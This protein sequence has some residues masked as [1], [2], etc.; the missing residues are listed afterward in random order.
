M[1]PVLELNLFDFLKRCFWVVKLLLRWERL[2]VLWVALVT[3]RLNLFDDSGNLHW[4][5][6]TQ[7]I[8]LYDLLSL[9]KILLER[10]KH[11]LELL[12]SSGL[13]FLPEFNI[14]I[15]QLLEVLFAILENAHVLTDLVGGV[16][17]RPFV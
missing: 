7:K 3:N 15:Q 16:A 14:L 2:K 8:L 6:L 11:L 13:F 1:T 10:A 9:S 5:D 17:S 12:V 4:L